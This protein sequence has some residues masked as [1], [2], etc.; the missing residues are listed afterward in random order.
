MLIVSQTR[1]GSSQGVLGTLTV[2][3]DMTKLVKIIRPPR[4]AA[5]GTLMALPIC[6]HPCQIMH[7]VVNKN[8]YEPFIVLPVEVQFPNQIKLPALF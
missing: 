8:A 1:V 7:I 2:A 6:L 4:I 3:G 5:G